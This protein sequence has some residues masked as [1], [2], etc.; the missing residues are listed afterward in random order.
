MLRF[1]TAG[2]SHGQCLTAILE[3]L[4]AGLAIDCEKINEKLARRQTGYGRGG[5]MKI[6]RDKADI[7]SGVRF[8]QT[9]GDPITLQ[10]RNH[11]WANWTEKMSV[12]GKPFGDKVTAARPGHADLIGVHKYDRTDIRDI[13]ERASARE[14][15][16]KV[17]IGSLCQQLLEQFN[18][19]TYS[20]VVKIGGISVNKEKIDYAK[21]ADNQSNLNC[22]DKAAEEKMHAAIRTAGQAGDT[23][24]GEFEVIVKGVPEGLGSHIQWDKRLDGRLAQAMMSIQAIK[25]VEI[26]EGVRYADNPGSQMHDEMFYD[27][28]KKVYRKTNHAGGLE[29]GM[30]NGEDV[31]VRAVM[32]P[33]PTL[34]QPLHSVDIA[35][36]EEVLAC[37]ERSDV[38]AVPAASIVGAAMVSYVIADAFLEQFGNNNLTDITASI[39]NYKKRLGKK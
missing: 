21:L 33:I 14:T 19:F 34:M 10:I 39:K 25:A 18:I 29:G 12:S 37:K 23:L 7:L 5:R 9:I 24:G 28:S 16:A 36:G 35:S 8:G 6:E 13:L 20:H 2:E 27:E 1:L 32:K 38:C 15:A 11:D 31:I 26:G 22:M 17:A 30:T 4:P 3:G